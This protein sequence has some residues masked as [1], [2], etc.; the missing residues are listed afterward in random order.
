MM[1]TIGGSE[2]RTARNTLMSREESRPAMQFRALIAGVAAALM[3]LL[4]P[5]AAQASH[6]F[7]VSKTEASVGEEVEFQI[8][9]T[10]A[11]E[12][13]IVR[14][15]DQ[16]VAS[17]VDNVGNGVTDR[18]EMPDFGGSNRAVSVEVD[19]TPLGDVNHTAPWP[20]TYL[21]AAGGA[22]GP[23]APQPVPITTVAETPTIVDE[24][25]IAAPTPTSK[26]KKAAKKK[27]PK[28]DGDG[29]GKK[30]ADT[31]ASTAP[32]NSGGTA[33]SPVASTGSE[34]SSDFSS[35]PS[36]PSSGASDVGSAA[37]PPGPTG[38]T[39]QP[40]GSAIASVLSPLSGIAE[41]G[42]TGFPILLILL[43]IILMALAL[44]AI[45][46]RVWQRYEPA[47]PWGPEAD[48]EV[49]LTAIRRASASGAQ[50]QQTIAE[51][52]ASRSAGRGGNGSVP[53][54]SGERAPIERTP[55]GRS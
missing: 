39:E 32:T 7:Y 52:K 1:G 27:A 26:E 35:T 46:P 51:R 4:G 49:R 45:G 11:G 3:L 28:S 55:V 40:V 43:A 42:K 53:A 37:P 33:P 14:V 17:G 19:V 41:P 24:P 20:M 13:Y 12:S 38:P 15:E 30:N 8:S 50:L 36:S 34:S 16:E 31:P 9:G 5:A 47:L 29:S 54:A 23:P 21:A 18:F 6:G 22:P 10:Q 44:T 48:D 2:H 25:Q